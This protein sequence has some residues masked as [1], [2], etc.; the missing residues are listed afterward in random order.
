MM[1]NI[2]LKGFFHSEHLL[3]VLF[4]LKNKIFNQT[5]WAR[6]LFPIRLKLEPFVLYAT[7]LHGAPSSAPIRQRCMLLGTETVYIA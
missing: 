7:G 4:L 6:K 5:K 2:H 3:L 1:L